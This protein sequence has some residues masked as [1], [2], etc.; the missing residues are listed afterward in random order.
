IGVSVE[1]ERV[2]LLLTAVALAASAVS[3]TG[4][5]SFIDLLAPHIAK[6]IG[7]RHQ[8]LMPIVILIG[9]WL[10]LFACTINLVE[11]DGIP[12]GNYGYAHRSSIF[13]IY[14]LMKK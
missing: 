9:G 11:S 4:R 12:A 8:I 13:L 5:M 2:A 6:T 10:V 1:K 3:G 7:P 14:L